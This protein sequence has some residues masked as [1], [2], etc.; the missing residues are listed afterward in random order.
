MSHPLLILDEPT[1]ELDPTNRR[2]VWDDLRRRAQDGAGVLVVSHNVHE[3]ATVAD[4]IIVLDKGRI[5]A[6]Q[7][8]Q[9]ILEDVDTLPTLIELPAGDAEPLIGERW[10]FEPGDRSGQVR[11]LVHRKEVD[12]FCAAL[13]A[14]RPEAF[15]HIRV[16]P[17]TLEDFY[18]RLQ[19]GDRSSARREEEARTDA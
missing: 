8:L 7:T 2:K 12:D 5:V 17:P 16:H 14:L 10:A 6:D 11:A 1:N 19:G 15:Q 13:H 18:L 9:S 4:R 3:A